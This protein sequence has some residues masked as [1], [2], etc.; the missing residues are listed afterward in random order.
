MVTDSI[1]GGG[2]PDGKNI[3]G[4]REKGQEVILEDGVAKMPDKQAFS[5]SAGIFVQF[6][7]ATGKVHLVFY[8]K[9]GA[10]YENSV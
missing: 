1:R 6:C 7:I 4:S 8:N 3:L 9:K 10:E 2:M 5:G